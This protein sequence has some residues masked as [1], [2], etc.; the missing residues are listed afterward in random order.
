MTP[1]YI[2]KLHTQSLTCFRWHILSALGL[3]PTFFLLFI[4]MTKVTVLQSVKSCYTCLLLIF[5]LF[6][7]IVPSIPY[8]LIISK[9]LYILKFLFKQI[10][11]FQL[12]WNTSLSPEVSIFLLHLQFSGVTKPK[13][14]A[15]LIRKCCF[16][17]HFSNTFF[18]HLSSLWI[19]TISYHL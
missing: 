14:G 16:S 8:T 9:C 19:Y 13:I 5:A 2:L 10:L 17:H 18:N 6:S 1:W 4:V 15:F 11:L 3:F 7:D 12:K